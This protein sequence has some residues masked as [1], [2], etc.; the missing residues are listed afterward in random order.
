MLRARVRCRRYKTQSENALEPLSQPQ[1]LTFE[2]FQIIDPLKKALDEANKRNAVEDLRIKGQAKLDYWV[3]AKA[4]MEKAKKEHET[5]LKP[6]P[7]KRR[8]TDGLA[9]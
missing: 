3:E 4:R 7:R 2:G 9:S 8:A 6:P 5:D 1:P